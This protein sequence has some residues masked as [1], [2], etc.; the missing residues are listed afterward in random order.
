M[1]ALEGEIR[2]EAPENLHLVGTLPFDRWTEWVASEIDLM[3]LPHVQGDPSGTYLEGMGCGA[4]FLAFA[5]EMSESLHREGLGWITPRGDIAVMAAV[6]RELSD[7]PQRIDE[8]RARGLDF[9]RA[10][11]YL[12]TSRRRVAHVAQIALEVLNR[13]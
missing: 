2:R 3:L 5:N 4:P 13:G 9:I 6:L 10:N 7:Q 12:E 11:P 1:G 8:Q